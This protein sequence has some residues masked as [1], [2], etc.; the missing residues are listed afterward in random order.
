MGVELYG[1]Q[2]HL[3]KLQLSLERTG[4]ELTAAASQ[5]AG[6][7]DELRLQRQAA[8]EEEAASKGRH[9]EVD[10]LQGQLDGLA[11]TLGQ[12]ER[13]HEQVSGEIAVTKRETYAAEEQVQRLE[14][15]K[16][17]QDFLI[18]H[19]Q[20][21][22][23]R[24]GRQLALHS[25]QLAAQQAETKSAR[26]VLARAVVDMEGVQYEKKALVGQWKASLVA[27]ARRDEALEVRC[28]DRLPL[29]RPALQV[30]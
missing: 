4:D 24:L 20:Q 29:L 22:I 27:M 23:E 1:F 10:A 9:Q 16:Q 17:R 5:R 2:Q 28:G 6:A 11:M 14:R 8:E 26:E 18:D 19:L 12:V 21:Q 15:A 25:A 7:D 30:V 13:H 3:A